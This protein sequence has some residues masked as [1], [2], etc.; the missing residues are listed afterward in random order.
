MSC[1]NGEHSFSP[2]YVKVPLLSKKD[3]KELLLKVA[4][5]DLSHAAYSFVE[6]HYSHDIC[7]KCGMMVY[8][9]E[10]KVSVKR[11][12]KLTRAIKVT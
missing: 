10:T 2:R 12:Q 5:S 4:S 7:D 6:E 8:P 11:I 3:I 1:K 9:D